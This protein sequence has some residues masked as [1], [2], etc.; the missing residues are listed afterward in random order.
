[1][2]PVRAR[3]E[4]APRAAAALVACGFA[5]A[6]GTAFAAELPAPV[7]LRVPS[8]QSIPEGALG[9]AV[10][11]GLSIVNA[12]QGA[13]TAYV[14]NGLNCASCHLNGGTV[15]FAAPLA[16]LWGVFPEYVTRSGRVETLADRINDCFVRSMNGRPLPPDSREMRAL[17]AYTAWLSTGVPTGSSVVGR[18]FAE[19][20][21]APRAPDPARGKA[22]YAQQCAA[23]HGADGGGLK[24]G[25]G[26]FAMPPLW[27][28]QSFNDGAGMARVS[29]AA[30]FVHA[31]MPLGRGNSLT[32]QD[33]W[34]VA[35]FF[36]DQPRPA[37]P[38]KAGDWPRGGKPADVR[39]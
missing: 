7:P 31:K 12:T 32:V 34:D 15:A 9:D 23:C 4:P 24:G 8:P 3:H 18:G 13:A 33:A 6:I 16:G 30:A 1:M 29:I 36:T 37:F 27:G 26:T 25:N 10:R 2:D 22:V 20:A 14:G 28:S 17:L 35:A 19:I 11:L 5:V 38:G 21:A 39:Y